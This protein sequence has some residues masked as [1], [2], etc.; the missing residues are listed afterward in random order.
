VTAADS[1]ALPSCSAVLRKVSLRLLPFM[2]I[3]YIMSYLDRI[4][5]SF[6]GLQ[7]NGEL[8]FDDSIFGLGAGIFF[9]GY[10]LFG[11][12][13]NVMVAKLGARKWISIIMVIWGG[14][15]MA[16]ALVRDPI[17]FYV[18][19]FLLG[20]AEAGF[21]PGMILYLT[22]WFPKRERGLA[23]AHFMTAIPVA[24]VLGGL[25]SSQILG[26]HGL[27]GLAGWKWLFIITGAP[28]V[29]LGII[30]AFTLTNN[31]Q[32]AKWLSEL[33]KKV[34]L[35][36]LDSERDLSPN[37]KDSL[38]AVLR[39]RTVWFFALIYFCM[40]LGMYGFQ[41][42][43]PQIIKA[44]GESNDQQTALLSAIPAVFQAMGMVLIAWNSDRV[45]ERRKHVLVSS[46]I[47]A[48][49]LVTS[50]LTASNPHVSFAALSIAA[51]GIWGSV[52]PF[53]AL[54]T[55][56]LSPA[57]AAV[58]IA[59]INSVGNLGGFAGPYLV[60][61]IKEHTHSFEWPLITMASS[62]LMVG[63]LTMLGSH[64]VHKQR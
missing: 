62:L 2:F 19:R 49:A 22:Y 4:N 26:M 53:W 47:A 17:S 11:V 27:Y 33:E 36:R 15:S 63:L 48:V 30:V 18:L 10:F 40:A 39:N 20:V 43:L 60:G 25:I 28:S 44:F 35:D 38:G 59:L 32:E 6:A 3:L 52:G 29:I 9:L 1:I 37:S 57:A 55:T 54:P 41:L 61:V 34:L 51:F 21:F 50:A 12:P 5:V 7:M 24:G 23:V 56:M 46:V 58:G 42:W 45:G 13:S 14:I 31:P 16:M 64:S 8:G